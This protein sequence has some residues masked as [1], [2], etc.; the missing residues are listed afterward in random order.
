M[1][2]K[3]II[4]CLS[5]INDVDL[6][7]HSAQIKRDNVGDCVYLRGLI[8]ISNICKKD[9][10]YCG[11]RCSNGNVDRYELTFEDVSNAIDY[12]I[13]QRFGSIVI[14]GGERSDSSFI[15]LINS[16]LEYA[17]AR[18]EG[19]L[20]ITLSLGEQSEN[21]Y[22]MWRELGAHRY[23]LRIESSSKQ[24]YEK[25]H[26]NG[27]SWDERIAGIERLR[28]CGFQVGTGV[29]IGLPF[30]KIEDLADDLL[31]FKE[32][33][34]DMCGMGPYIEHKDTPLY[35]FESDFK[36]QDRVELTLR[37]IA[38][39]RIMMPKINIASTTALQTLDNQGF[40]K[41]LR[42]GANI[43]MP[44]ITPMAA[45]INYNLYQNKPFSTIDLT[46]FNVAYDQW[47][48]SKHF[49]AKQK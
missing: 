43:M 27:Y 45:R 41:G 48:D 2:L 15:K 35:K 14:Q 16:C 44:N 9:C 21:V 38:L 23:L 33:D 29:M 30:Q 20:G 8:E 31:F 37:M 26:P 12:A 10:L 47:G 4:D 34:I 11:I 13:E 28:K 5:G 32:L 19:R 1:T 17:K 40:E 39:L 22:Q 7:L 46:K 18:S 49:A 24:I 6:F 42:V 25:I 3:N 36:I